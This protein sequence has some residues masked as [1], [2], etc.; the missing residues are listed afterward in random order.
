MIADGEVKPDDAYGNNKSDQAADK[1]VTMEQ[2][3]L[4][5]IATH[6]ANKHKKYKEL[7]RRV[8]TFIVKTK[9]AERKLRESKRKE[10]DPFATQAAENTT[11]PQPVKLQKMQRPTSSISS[12]AR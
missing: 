8:H 6:Y 9:K 12:D 4:T 5:K 1:G 3:Q 10:A 7:M 11:F 2:P